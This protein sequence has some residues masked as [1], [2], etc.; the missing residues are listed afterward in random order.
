ML[1]TLLQ[2]YIFK[3]RYARWNNGKRENF[4]ESI[5]R[6]ISFFCEHLRDKHGYIMPNDLK[7][8]IRQHIADSVAPSM[9]CLANAG[10]YLK[11]HNVAGYNCAFTPIDHPKRYGEMLYIL[12]CTV[13]VGFSVESEEISKL[14]AIPILQEVDTVIVVEDSAFGW[15]KALNDYL[16]EL[17]VGNICKVDGSKVRKK[18]A[19]LKTKG[20]FAAGFEQLQELIEFITVI[21]KNAQG[22]KLKP[23]EAHDIGCKVGEVV[24]ISSRRAAEISLS[25]LNDSEM[26]LAKSGD[27][28]FENHG[29]RRF[30]NNSAV[31]DGRP[32]KKVFDDEWKALKDS[33]TGERGILNRQALLKKC[34]K[35]GRDLKKRYGVNPCA[36]IIL[37]L[38]FCNLTEV[39]IRHY[40][41]FESVRKKIRI[42]TILGT[43]QSTLTDFKFLS[44]EWKKNCEDEHL[45]GV[46]LTGIYDNP[47]FYE[48][49]PELINFLES[50]R[51]MAHEINAEYSKILG[52]KKSVAITCNKPS[53]TVS[54][55]YDCSSGLHPRYAEYY[56]RTVR[57][58][59]NDV[60]TKFLIS[61]GVQNEPC[62]YSR[63]AETVVFNFYVKSPKHAKTVGQVSAIDH[64]KLWSIYQKYWCDHN[65]SVTIYIRE[66][67]WDAVKTWIW[68]NFDD[69]A[70][71]SFLPLD[72]HVYQ[73]APLQEISALRYYWER[74]KAFFKPVDW[75]KL[76]EFED[77]TQV[78]QEFS[79]VNG[80]CEI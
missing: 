12:L 70:G 66:N 16:F 67:E 51:I 42:A 36:E 1:K 68:E 4:N 49:T 21:F 10:E 22:R 37:F 53:G 5:E 46:S 40:D 19:K 54:L 69:V 65:P 11:D 45:L 63:N 76:H 50:S 55:F 64:L 28:W 3:S 38:E 39:I 62:I 9:R 13:G 35:L 18:G 30:A 71:I 2:Q 29:Y 43:M 26:R 34:K 60:L 74:F 32:D 58:N 47:L 59:S 17:F 79:C 73:Q 44:E 80:S 78:N 57:G 20:G 14:P 41:T 15:A 77:N 61:Q 7:N 56:R 31:Y 25:D 6:Y 24:Q 33:G 48:I 75:S 23:I 8:E 52:I 72:E 27:K